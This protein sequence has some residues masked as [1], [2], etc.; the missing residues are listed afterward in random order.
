MQVYSLFI[1]YMQG[2]TKRCRLS[3]LTNSTLHI[4]V[5]MREEGG[6]GGVAGSQ[7]MST[8]VHITWHGAQINFGDLPLCLH[9][10]LMQVGAVLGC[11]TRCTWSC[12]RWRTPRSLC[13]TPPAPPRRFSPCSSALPSPSTHLRNQERRTLAQ[14]TRKNVY[15]P[16][17]LPGYLINF[18]RKFFKIGPCSKV[19]YTYLFL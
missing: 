8:A 15:F 7:P 1:P 13:T 9:V 5:Q 2:V 19:L 16:K 6:G 12:T 10:N 14:K 11:G 3:L 4:R 17:N 18:Y